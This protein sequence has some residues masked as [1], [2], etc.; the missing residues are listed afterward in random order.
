MRIND[1]VTSGFRM[2]HEVNDSVP[3]GFMM[4]HE[5]KS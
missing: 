2:L 5:V 1:S 4:S 3:S